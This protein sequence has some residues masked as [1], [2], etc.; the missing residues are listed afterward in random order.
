MTTQRDRREA[1]QILRRIVAALPEPTPTQVAF[2]LG[3]ASGLDRRPG[4]L[5]DPR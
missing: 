3:Q 1:A 5:A 4:S 2:M